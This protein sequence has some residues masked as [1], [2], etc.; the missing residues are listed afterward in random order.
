MLHSFGFS[1]LCIFICILKLL[2]QS[3]LYR[4]GC[5]FFTF[6]SLDPS[7]FSPELICW[8]FL[9]LTGG[10]RA[11]AAHPPPVGIWALLAVGEWRRRFRHPP[12]ARRDPPLVGVFPSAGGQ[13]TISLEYQINQPHESFWYSSNWNGSGCTKLGGGRSGAQAELVKLVKPV[14]AAHF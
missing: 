10:G 7:R 2:A 8:G 11:S 12:P 1:P 5:T 6:Q 4:T 9:R 14:F 13:L 3:I